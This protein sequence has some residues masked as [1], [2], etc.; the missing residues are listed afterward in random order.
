MQ[1]PRGSVHWDSD[2]ERGV[3]E[4]VAKLIRFESPQSEFGQSCVGAVNQHQEGPKAQYR[5]H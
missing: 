4:W 5:L 3:G 2:T 1:V